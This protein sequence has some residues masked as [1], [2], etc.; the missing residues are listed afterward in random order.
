M[1]IEDIISMYGTSDYMDMNTYYIY[2]ISEAIYDESNNS[3]KIPV[4]DSSYGNLIGYVTIA[5]KV[6]DYK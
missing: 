6:E 5:G 3:S 4:V 1:K 2:K